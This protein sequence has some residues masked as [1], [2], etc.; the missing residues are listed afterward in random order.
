MDGECEVMEDA[1]AARTGQLDRLFRDARSVR[2]W[3]ARTV[4]EALLRELYALMRMGPTAANCQPTRI[5]FVCTAAARDRLLPLMDPG[6][7]EPTRQAPVT[8]IVAYDLR[9][10]EKLPKLYAHQPQAASWFNGTPAIAREAALRNGSLQGGYLIMAAR[11][12]GLDCGPMGGFDGLGAAQAFFPGQAVEVNFMCNLGYRVP[13]GD[14]PRL[15]RLEF[16][17]SCAIV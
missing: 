16:E 6:N 11:A 9:F 3:Q 15:P 17:E 1:A 2:A 13:G 14:H 7:V 8:A 10:Y 4:P 12:L 5:A